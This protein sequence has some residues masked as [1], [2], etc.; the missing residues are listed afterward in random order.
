MMRQYL[1]SALSFFGSF[2]PGS[3]SAPG[4]LLFPA[5]SG[6]RRVGGDDSIQA[7][8]EAGGLAELAVGR[9]T[10]TSRTASPAF[11]TASPC[12]VIGPYVLLT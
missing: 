1:T 4:N 6:I 5:V 10:A 2:C 8:G 3:H 12:A 9:G 7:G 11:R